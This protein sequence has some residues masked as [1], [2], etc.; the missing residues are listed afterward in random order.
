MVK[1]IIIKGLKDVVLQNRYKFKTDSDCEVI[2]YLYRE[3]NDL[4]LNMLDGVFSFYLYDESNHDFLVARDPIG[5]NPLYYGIN[6]IGEYC[7]ASEFKA[8][9]EWDSAC[10]IK[11]FPPGHYMNKSFELKGIINLIGLIIKN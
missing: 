2:L 8:I 6:N 3:L 5:V 9:R 11:I 1:F 10:E 7:F 4:F